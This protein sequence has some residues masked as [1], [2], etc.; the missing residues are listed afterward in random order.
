MKALL[1]IDVQNDFFPGGTL[2]VATAPEILPALNYLLSCPFDFIIATKDW[3]PSNHTSF[4]VNHNKIPGEIATLDDGIEQIMWPEHC[5]QETL[6]AEFAPGWKT[7]KVQKIFYKG[8]DRNVD[9][10][11]AFFDHRRD[12]ATGLE[13]YLRE[14]QVDTLY[15]VGLA[16]DYC[17]LYSVLD[18]LTLGFK[19]YVVADACRGVD[20]APDDSAA[21]LQKMKQAGAVII[22]LQNFKH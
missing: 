17:V 19:A 14:H 20:L 4:A 10:Y 15:V 9:S 11:S 5:V 16:T 3:H 12:K 22:E 1:I 18:A 7:E 8:T 13:E 2:P 21:A 6:G